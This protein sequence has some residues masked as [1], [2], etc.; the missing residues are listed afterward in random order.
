[1]RASRHLIGLPW[2]VP[3]DAPRLG[4]LTLTS[5]AKIRSQPAPIRPDHVA[6]ASAGKAGDVR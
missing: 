6:F 4:S 5:T 2:R 1:M 3:D